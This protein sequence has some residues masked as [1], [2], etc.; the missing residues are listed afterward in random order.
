ME[1][2]GW[3]PRSVVRPLRRHR[4][5]CKNFKSP[6]RSGLGN[7]EHEEEPEPGQDGGSGNESE[8]SRSVVYHPTGTEPQDGHYGRHE[9]KEK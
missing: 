3:F 6:S 4:P 1:V 9:K 5:T 2:K 8:S 7:S